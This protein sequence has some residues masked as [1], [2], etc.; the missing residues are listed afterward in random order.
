VKPRIGI[1]VSLDVSERRRPGRR[2]HYSETRYAEAVAHAGGL[3]LYLPPQEDITELL[4]YI[5]GLLLPGGDDF[6]PPAPYTVPVAF[7]PVP[8]EQLA[9]DRCLLAGALAREIPVFGICYGMQ[10]MALHCGGR[11]HHHLPLDLPQ[12]QN[13]KLDERSGRHLI[14]VEPGTRLAALWPQHEATVNSLHHQAVAEPGTDLRVCARAT[15][16]VIEAIEGTRD[17]FLLGVQWH[18]EKLSGTHSDALFHAFVDT[19][20]TQ[21]TR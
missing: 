1:S 19:C 7:E 12:A 3:A 8:E 15:D 20:R 5:D 6:L 9:F 21:R 4:D 18:P 11:L 13:H 2:Y 16:G 14:H 10:L 17:G